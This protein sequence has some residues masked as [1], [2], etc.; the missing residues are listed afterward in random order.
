M[1][2]ANADLEGRGGAP[3]NTRQWAQTD[4]DSPKLRPGKDFLVV[5]GFAGW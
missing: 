5:G 1:K 3:E 2:S 4:I